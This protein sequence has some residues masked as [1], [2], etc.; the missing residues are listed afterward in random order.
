MRRMP[1]QTG[2]RVATTTPVTS[3]ARC[4]DL[5]CAGG[6]WDCAETATM[7]TPT[8]TA[9]AML[10]IIAVILACICRH[11]YSAQPSLPRSGPHEAGS[12]KVSVGVGL[13]N[14]LHRAK[15]SSQPLAHLRPGGR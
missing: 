7:M 13:W 6:V 1:A 8:S 2:R 15:C 14:S 5:Y 10:T 9:A 12:V 4:C 11:P 3:T